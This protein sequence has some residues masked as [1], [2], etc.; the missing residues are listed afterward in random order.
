MSLNGISQRYRPGVLAV[1]PPDDDG[2]GDY[3][4]DQI[5]SARVAYENPESF[6]CALEMHANQEQMMD[7][8]NFILGNPQHPGFDQRMADLLKSMDAQL[9]KIVLESIQHD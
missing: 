6:A 2:L 5:K 8:A 1:S 9:E 4:A 3:V 7:I